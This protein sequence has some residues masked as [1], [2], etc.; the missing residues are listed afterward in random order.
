MD[1]FKYILNIRASKIRRLFFKDYVKSKESVSVC[2]YF[3]FKQKILLCLKCI[4][5]RIFLFFPRLFKQ[6]CWNVFVFLRRAEQ[7]FRFSLETDN[8]RMKLT[9]LIFYLANNFQ[10]AQPRGAD[11]ILEF[12]SE[13][14]SSQVSTFCLVTLL[15]SHFITLVSVSQHNFISSGASLFKIKKINIF[16]GHQYIELEFVILFC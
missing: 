11:C 13:L 8:W 2:F 16:V 6:N 15:S 12:Y 9:F 4:H 1:A 10:Q 5:R 7:S 3:W 14:F